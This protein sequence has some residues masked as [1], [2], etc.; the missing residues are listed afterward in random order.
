MNGVADP[1][2]RLF[3]SHELKA[4]TRTSHPSSLRATQALDGVPHPSVFRRVR[5]VTPPF[6]A[7]ASIPDSTDT[8]SPA[9][10]SSRKNKKPRFEFIEPGLS[11]V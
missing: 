10:P 3:A 6:T 7:S 5:E 8:A 2:F 1:P 4:R 9:D 11:F